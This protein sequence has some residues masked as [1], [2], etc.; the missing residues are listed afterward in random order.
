[1][2]NTT[3]RSKDQEEK[4]SPSR[5]PA[6]TPPENQL[7]PQ[8]SLEFTHG[9]PLVD[10][11][12]FRQS[13]LF[14]GPGGAGKS[15]L[16]KQLIRCWYTEQ[17]FLNRP[18]HKPAHVYYVEGDRSQ[19]AKTFYKELGGF[20]DDVT[21]YSIISRT[22]GLRLEWIS[23]PDNAA[24]LLDHVLLKLRP[25]PG[26]VLIIDPFSPFFVK[27]ED[28]DRRAV[29]ASI[30][31][32]TRAQEDYGI[33]TIFLQHFNKEKTDRGQR[34]ARPWERFN[35]AGAWFHFSDNALWIVD[36]APDAKES[37]YEFGWK[38]RHIPW[39]MARLTRNNSHFE[40]YAGAEAI[41]PRD[42]QFYGLVPLVPTWRSELMEAAEAAGIPEGTARHSLDRLLAGGW[43]EQP[44][45][46]QYQRAKAN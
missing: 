29:A 5:I 10:L 43:V 21:F 14:G 24:A 6:P 31:R 25:I 13:T 18:A 9:D 44:A 15:T 2:R 34:Y 20:D 38:P 41:D 22:S 35:G 40:F 23:E 1:M 19:S 26:S 32:L 39:G 11:I 46:G 17:P 4:P 12:P 30:I 7:H 16:L 45:H 3:A 42:V 33:T 36:P 8:V 27:G 28:G 37:W